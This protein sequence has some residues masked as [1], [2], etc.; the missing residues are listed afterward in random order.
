VAGTTEQA[1]EQ[2]A[3]LQDGLVDIPIVTVPRQ[4]ADVAMETV[5]ALAPE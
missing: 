2:L 1:R 5:E 3:E 4:A